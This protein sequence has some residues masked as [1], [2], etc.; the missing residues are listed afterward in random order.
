MA[1]LRVRAGLGHA[2]LEMVQHYAQMVDED[3]L[4][5]TGHIRR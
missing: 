3:L 4:R 2:G 1:P 5:R